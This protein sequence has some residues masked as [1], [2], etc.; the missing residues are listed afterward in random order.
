MCLRKILFPLLVMFLVL[1]FAPITHATKPI[2][3]KWAHFVGK[4]P[5]ETGGLIDQFF[6]D[7]VNKR[8]NGRVKIEIYWSQTLG[9]VKELLGLVSNGTVDIAV[10]PAGYF[11]SSF[12]LWAAPNS[13]PFVMETL[14]QAWQTHNKIPAEIGAVKEE[15]KKL[16]IKLLYHHTIAPYQLFSTKPVIKFEDLKGMKVRSWGS[17]IP[18]AYQAAGAVSVTI[19]PAENYEALKRGLVDAVMWPLAHGSGLKIHEVAPIISMWNIG[20]F[21]GR[22]NWINLDSWKKLP[23]DVQK[24]MLDVSKEASKMEANEW[25]KWTHN[26]RE[27]MDAAGVKYYEVPEVERQKW[28][29]A[30][31]D[32][33]AD[34]VKAMEKQG[35]G[36]AARQM[37][38]RWLKIVEEYRTE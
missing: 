15:A 27:K 11:P 28:I 18:K 24:I 9:K 22:G 37:K 34:W 1:S 29:K 21:V 19:F 8:T 13:I 23:A 36:D 20:T 25:R 26:A 2:V 17:Y 10:V 16:N 38:K 14:E 7:E 33:L 35:K 32:F 4:S 30:C 12:P 6:A 5:P 31:P 3:L